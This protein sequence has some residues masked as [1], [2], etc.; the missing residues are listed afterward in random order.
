M[1]GYGPAFPALVISGESDQ[2]CIQTSE[3][4]GRAIPGPRV[5]R[6]LSR[7]QLVNEAAQTTSAGPEVMAST[8]APVSLLTVCTQPG[9]RRA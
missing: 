7:E 9:G 6:P 1:P 2:A 3:V 8:R 5:S 4:T